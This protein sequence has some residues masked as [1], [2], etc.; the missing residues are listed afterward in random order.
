MVHDPDKRV[1]C[2]G[3]GAGADGY[4][5]FADADQVDHQR[6]GEDGSAATD[7]GQREPHRASGQRAQQ[8]LQGGQL[9][10][11]PGAQYAA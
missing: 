6:H 1:G 2:N 11:F 9:P 7:E 4:M 8:E 5:R 10:V 3:E